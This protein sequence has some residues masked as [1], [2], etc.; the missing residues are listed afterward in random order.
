[1]PAGAPG[2]QYNIHGNKKK[3]VFIVSKEAD[4]LNHIT[5]DKAYSPPPPR[6]AHWTRRVGPPWEHS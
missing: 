1:M 5:Q 3:I 2:P 6:A 4:F